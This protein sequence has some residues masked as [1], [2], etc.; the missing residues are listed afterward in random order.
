MT[1]F[2]SFRTLP[3][4]HQV[5]LVISWVFLGAW[6]VFTLWAVLRPPLP[7]P[8]LLRVWEPQILVCGDGAGA[9]ARAEAVREELLYLHLHYGAPMLHADGPKSC[10]LPPWQR[11]G[12]VYVHLASAR[13]Y[14]RGHEGEWIPAGEPW[15]GGDLFLKADAEPIV[16]RHE[17]LH[18]WL[19][20]SEKV[21]HVM[22]EI[23][24]EDDDGIARQMQELSAAL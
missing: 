15:Y 3:L 6:M 9:Q 8:A 2:Q 7:P 4:A 20:H 21:N 16:L 10:H 14:G 11:A 23:P 22:S 1:W 18:L 13:T 5:L 12:T 17:L 24:G 19:G